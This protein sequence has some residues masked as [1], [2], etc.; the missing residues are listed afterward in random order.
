MSSHSS[1]FVAITLALVAA[2]SSF[3]LAAQ[4]CMQLRGSPQVCAARTSQFMGAPTLA[5]APLR[6]DD[7]RVA[8]NINGVT[9]GLFGLGWGEIAVIGAIGALIFG[10][11][12]LAGLGKDLGKVAGSL[13]KEAATFSEAMNETLDEVNK[14]VK[15]GEA[16]AAQK[17][18][19]PAPEAKPVKKK[20]D[21]SDE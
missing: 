11:K 15:A 5:L 12:N 6:L 13:K 21:L 20:V 19:P 1:L 16:E 17:S 18:M 3:Q 7:R 9:M 8:S 14:E 4:P 10:P 2:S